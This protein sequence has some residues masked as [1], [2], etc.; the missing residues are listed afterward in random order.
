MVNIS[1]STDNDSFRDDGG[2]LDAE[3]VAEVLEALVLRIREGK[4][5]GTVGDMNGNTVGRYTVED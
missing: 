4:R 1:F 3:A 5:S 2:M